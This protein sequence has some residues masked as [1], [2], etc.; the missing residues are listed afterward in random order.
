MSQLL[1]KTSKTGKSKAAATVTHGK[2]KRTIAPRAQHTVLMRER[3][4]GRSLTAR[5]FPIPESIP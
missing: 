5:A 3:W 4:G 2:A 1:A